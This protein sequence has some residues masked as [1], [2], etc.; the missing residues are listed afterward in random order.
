M[1]SAMFR[2]PHLHHVSGVDAELV[3]ADM[4]QGHALTYGSDKHQIEET[5][6]RH[7]AAHRADTYLSVA[8]AGDTARPIPAVCLLI[9]NEAL[10]QFAVEVTGQVTSGARCVVYEQRKF[11]TASTLAVVRLGD[12]SAQDVASRSPEAGFPM[13]RA[14]GSAFCAAPWWEATR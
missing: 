12:R 7:G 1:V 3:L 13:M 8:C 6:G 2:I 5:M 14:L 11:A 10:E 4:M 9:K